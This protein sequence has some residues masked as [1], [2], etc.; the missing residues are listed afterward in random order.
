VVKE[1]LSL[2]RD[3]FLSQEEEEEDDG[4][5]EGGREGRGERW[6]EWS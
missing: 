1:T 5:R 3:L 2:G 6:R 4:G